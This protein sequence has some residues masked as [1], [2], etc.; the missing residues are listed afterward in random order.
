MEHLRN[1]TQTLDLPGTPF[2]VRYDLEKTRACVRK[3]HD[4][5]RTLAEKATGSVLMAAL[6]K[7]YLVGVDPAALEAALPRLLEGEPVCIARAKDPVP[8]RDGFIRYAFAVGLA[9]HLWREDPAKTP[10]RVGYTTVQAGTLLAERVPPPEPLEGR[11]IFGEPIPAELGRP[12]RLRAGRNVR[13]SEDG[14]SAHAEIDGAAKLVQS[15][16]AVDPVKT[17]PSDVDIRSGNIEFDGDVIVEGDVQEGFSVDAAGSIRVAGVVYRAAMRSGGDIIADGGLYGKDGV[18]IEAAGDLLF[19]FAESA[20]LR[21]GAG[22]Y[23]RRSMTNCLAHAEG[24]VF[25]GATGR[26][27]IGG[28]LIAAQGV[29][30]CSLGNP[31]LATPTRIEF[32]LRPRI[33]RRLRSLRNERP[34]ASKDRN[35]EI[36]EELDAL[37]EDCRRERA[38]RVIVR[39]GAYPGVVLLS[40]SAKHE[41]QSPTPPTV[42]Y[43]LKGAKEISM[44]PLESEK[45][46]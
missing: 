5:P 18:T 22:I 29:E 41:I 28:H 12:A 14:A 21:A 23:A 39:D 44:R 27:L 46:A 43:K 38:A 4:M 45:P 34:A 11:D 26:A 42:F 10:D 33:A 1:R 30:A 8:G 16:I 25:L 19:A 3:M 7:T 36:V 13:L 9:E 6:E 15:R 35:G 40:G 20:Q 31:I 24:K 32:G 17:I 37:L 2:Y